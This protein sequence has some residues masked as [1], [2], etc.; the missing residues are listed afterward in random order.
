VKDVR[1]KHETGDVDAV[2][3]GELDDFIKEYLLSRRAITA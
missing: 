2:L 3:N 1:T